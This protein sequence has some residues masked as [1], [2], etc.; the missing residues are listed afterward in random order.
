MTGEKITKSE[1]TKL[2][3]KM[4][5][6]KMNP[7]TKEVLSLEVDEAIKFPCR[8]GHTT[9]GICMGGTNIQ[10]TAKRHGLQV[11]C[12]CVSQFLHVLRVQ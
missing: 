4:F 10:G 9:G 1:F 5:T 7:E 8:W 3:P 12:R 2:G 6:A 11:S